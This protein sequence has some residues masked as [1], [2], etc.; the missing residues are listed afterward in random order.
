MWNLD[1][2]NLNEKNTAAIL[3]ADGGP[4][5]NRTGDLR[6]VRAPS[7]P[8]DHEPAVTPHNPQDYLIGAVGSEK[9]TRWMKRFI[10]IVP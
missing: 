8:L 4:G 5:R 3:N 9:N 10:P 1:R 6:L 7:E 2:I